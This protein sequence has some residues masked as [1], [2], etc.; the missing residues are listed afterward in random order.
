MLATGH[1]PLQVPVGTVDGALDKRF[2]LNP[3][4]AEGYEDLTKV[5]QIGILGTGLTAMDVVGALDALK[6]QGT[7]TL[8]SRRGS[9]LFPSVSGGCSTEFV[10]ENG[11]FADSLRGL[12]R[13]VRKELRE[14]VEQGRDWHVIVDAFRPHTPAIWKHLSEFERGQFLRHLRSYWEVARHRM[15]ER[16]YRRV[17]ELEAEGRLTICRGRVE[18]LDFKSD[19]QL[20]NLRSRHRGTTQTSQ[21]ERVFNCAGSGVLTA[22]NLP[23][24]LQSLKAHNAIQFDRFGLGMYT[25]SS[26]ELLDRDNGIVRG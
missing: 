11:A 6:F 22:Q 2:V 19:A 16:I 24:I 15:P 25:A 14:Y 12:V 4:S 26:G 21:F 23:P 9:F 18:A 17:R 8:F 20:V 10:I 1:T 13:R 7:I 3:W 5:S